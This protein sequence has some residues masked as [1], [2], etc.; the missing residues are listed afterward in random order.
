MAWTPENLQLL[1]ARRRSN[2][3]DFTDTEVRGASKGC[4]DLKETLSAFGNMPGGG[5]VILGLDASNGYTPTG[6]ED[7]A[8]L[9]TLVA[10][11]ARTAVSPEVQVSF[12]RV[13]LDGETVVMA[14]VAG[15]APEARP[16]RTV[17]GNLAYLRQPDGQYRIS[18]QEVQQL[19]AAGTRPRH[20][21]RPVDETSIA[22]LDPALR[23]N[24]IAVAR[25]TS[26]RLSEVSDEEVLRFKRVV[27]PQGNRLT[28]AGL[29]ALGRYPQQFEPHLSITAVAEPATRGEVRNLAR[30][31]FDGPLPE[32]LDRAVEWVQR[33][34]RTE[35]RFGSNGHGQ[36]ETEMP[37]VAVR[38]LLANALVH[39]DLGPHTTGKNVQI[40]LTGDQL[41]VSSPGGLWGLSQDQ[42]GWPGAKS[43]VNEFLYE[44]CKL[45]R[46]ASSH[47]VVEGE[48]GGLREVRLALRDAGL[49]RPGFNDNGVRFTASIPRGT[50]LTSA[51]RQ[52]LGE[53]RTDSELSELQ[54]QLLVSMH[55]GQTWTGQMV[56]DEFGL[57]DPAVAV[58]ALRG[59]VAA[60][61]A[62]ATG[63]GNSFAIAPTLVPAGVAVAASPIDRSPTTGL[64]VGEP[65]EHDTSVS[66]AAPALRAPEP[67]KTSKNAAAIL[68]ELGSVPVE[69]A[70]ISAKTGL[71]ANQIRYAL[72]PLLT[73]GVVVREGGQGHKV[74]TYSRAG[75]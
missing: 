55:H 15:L 22:D 74:T 3:G 44:I 16:C 11:Q 49:R 20:D 70:D 26:R 1:L 10:S 69:V 5:T 21:T 63:K 51:D 72:S 32:L 8:A 52:W 23:E 53:L 47:R 25:S 29:Y 50:P 68:R 34:T 71:T 64:S 12:E 40:R 27:E 60:G 38:E 46:T 24:F 48:G 7:P 28:L 17:Q 65:I 19:V 45:T 73:S 66:T 57:V 61:L 2:A 58:A 4:P 18:D 33:N 30:V 42:L 36:D 41:V 75:S 37:M 35:V 9:E 62:A 6:I 54:K 56:N 31:E 59:I 13:V 43:S 67:M 14:K 39:R